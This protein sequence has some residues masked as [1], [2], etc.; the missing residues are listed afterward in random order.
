MNHKEQEKLPI[1]KSGPPDTE[2]KE[3]TSHH[4][5]F[6]AI[7][8]GDIPPWDDDQDMNLSET[9][10]PFQAIFITQ[11]LPWDDDVGNSG[12]QITGEIL[13]WDGE[14]DKNPPK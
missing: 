13:L 6:Q 14:E 5:H 9:Q 3:T 1:L 2:Q 12:V 11:I 7:C 4:I 10:S 8:T